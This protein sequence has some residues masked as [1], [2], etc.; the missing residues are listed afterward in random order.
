MIVMYDE[1]VVYGIDHHHL[2]VHIFSRYCIKFLLKNTMGFLEKSY[3]K[4]TGF[5][6]NESS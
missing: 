3:E 4:D 6:H 2:I 1:S 5:E